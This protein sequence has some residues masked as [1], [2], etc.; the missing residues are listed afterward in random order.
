MSCAGGL[1]LPYPKDGYWTDITTLKN[2]KDIYATECFAP[3]NCIGGDSAAGCFATYDNLTGCLE[4]AGR[5]GHSMICAKGSKGRLCDECEEDYFYEAG[6][7]CM[8]CADG[9]S[10]TGSLIV[11]VVILGALAVTFVAIKMNPSIRISAWWVVLTNPARFKIIW[12]TA[13]IVATIRYVRARPS[14]P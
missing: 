12:A 1:A 2:M 8:E 13:Q 7:G 5:F 4:S 9:G 10:L 6:A 3:D 11:F 14:L